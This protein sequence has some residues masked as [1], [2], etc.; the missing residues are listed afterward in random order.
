MV[1]DD[2]DLPALIEILRNKGD[3]D[4]VKSSGDL[5]AVKKSLSVNQRES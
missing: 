4:I 3:E 2:E 5:N 1:V